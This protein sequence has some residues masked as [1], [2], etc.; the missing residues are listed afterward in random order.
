LLDIKNAWRDP[1]SHGKVSYNDTAARDI[2]ERMSRFMQ[3]LATLL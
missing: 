1:S 3:Q 2:F